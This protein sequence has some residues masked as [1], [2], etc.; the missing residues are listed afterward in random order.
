MGGDPEELRDRYITLVRETL[1]FSLWPQP[2]QPIEVFEPQHPGPVKRVALR[3]LR[4]LS[5]LLRF[6]KLLIARDATPDPARLERGEV[7]PFPHYGETM[8]GPP[9]MENLEYCV[10]TVLEEGVTGDLIETGV[11]RGGACIFMRAILAAYGVSDRTVFVADSFRGLPPPDL[12]NPEDRGSRFHHQRD[13]RV[14]IESVRENFRKYDLLDE[15]V[16]FLEGWFAD[17]LP[18]ARIDHLA[19]LRL[20]GDMYGSTMDSLENLYPK[21]VPGGFV[22]VD[23]YRLGPC[24]AAVTEYR[25]SQGI[26]DEIL[27]VD[28]TGIYWRKT[29]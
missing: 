9:R 12:D 2:P 1:Q 25:E 27:A 5:G 11:W 16:V 21:L 14:D 20:D 24:R 22:I 6:R 4:L 29:G 23:D 17:T 28:W 26:E 13:L 3:L 18:D 15:Q 10:R 8:L 19:V 7:W